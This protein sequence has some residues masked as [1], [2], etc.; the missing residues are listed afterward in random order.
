MS[1]QDP[2]LK[3]SK[4]HPNADSRILI[5]DSD[6]IIRKKI[7]V[8]VTDSE[9]SISYDPARRPAVSNLLQLCSY[10]DQEG[11]SPEE[12]AE[13]CK[14]MLFRDFKPMLSEK[15]ISRLAPIRQEFERVMREEGYLE[16]VEREGAKKAK[17]NAEETMVLVRKAVGL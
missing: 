17:E 16:S 2:Q 1:L 7:K 15:I 8:A 11:R 9:Y 5:T 13:A 12:L 3:M 10:V 14:D 4:S 6:E